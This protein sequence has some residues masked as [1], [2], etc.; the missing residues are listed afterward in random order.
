MAD[1]KDHVKKSL[2]EKVNEIASGLASFGKKITDKATI[3]AHDFFYGKDYQCNVPRTSCADKEKFD[4]TTTEV[5]SIDD[6][7]PRR[8]LP[9]FYKYDSI[10]T[11]TFAPAVI[12][13]LLN[14]LR[15]FYKEGCDKKE[16]LK[17]F[18]KKM[19]ND[20]DERFIEGITTQYLIEK[21]ASSKYIAEK[22]LRPVITIDDIAS[23][24]ELKHI[25][26]LNGLDVQKYL[27]KAGI[28]P[29]TEAMET[30]DTLSAYLEIKRFSSEKPELPKVLENLFG[31]EKYNPVSPIVPDTVK[32]I[33]GIKLNHNPTE[34][35]LR[36]AAVYYSNV[37]AEHSQ[38][39]DLQEICEPHV[40][41]NSTRE[42][43][44]LTDVAMF[45]GIKPS[46]IKS[47]TRR[48]ERDPSVVRTRIATYGYNLSDLD[49]T[50]RISVYEDMQT[51][52]PFEVVAKYNLVDEGVAKRAYKAGE[53]LKMNTK[54]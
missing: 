16:A 50:T 19:G 3:A 34:E 13:N 4:V 12:K 35:D 23:R 8:I 27:I 33:R 36:T 14:D 5:D 54:I 32:E 49:S 26:S 20:Y 42:H 48:L 46:K 15:V 51:M 17:K 21:E 10:K 47:F 25:C 41:I 53:R 45:T 44:N 11:P 28:E 29:T 6:F 40:K 9:P 39:Y 52:Q 7:I 24:D 1:T 2:S 18:M 31:K 38:R 30:I 37:L 43:N 22:N